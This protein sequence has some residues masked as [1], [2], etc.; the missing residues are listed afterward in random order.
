MRAGCTAIVSGTVQ[1]V[2]FRITTRRVASKYLVDGT[3]RN[4]SDGTVRIEA[5]GEKAE[6]EAFIAALK[7]S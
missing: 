2:G 6:V 7:G 4:L 3:V 5:D 1:G